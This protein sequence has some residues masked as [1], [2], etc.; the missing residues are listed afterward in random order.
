MST[1]TP[2]ETAGQIAMRLIIYVRRNIALQTAELE[3][4]RAFHRVEE[5]EA[6]L[7]PFAELADKIPADYPDAVAC[8]TT[9]QCP[10]VG[11]IRRAK[12]VVEKVG[13]L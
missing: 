11:D 2:K 6:A 3:I 10:S 8:W 9:Q 5:L 7:K 1:T 12:Q 4:I 13:A